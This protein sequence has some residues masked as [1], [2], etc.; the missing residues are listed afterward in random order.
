MLKKFPSDK[1]RSAKNV[2]LFLSRAPTHH[3]FTFS[4]RFLFELKHR[5]RQCFF[6]MPS[7]N[8]RKPV[9]S[10][11]QRD[12]EKENWSIMGSSNT[13][14]LKLKILEPIEINI[15]QLR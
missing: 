3:S 15:L 4:L 2:L 11:C 1:I 13:F 7:E 12:M 9:V 6:S 8:I 10:I 5:V 14:F